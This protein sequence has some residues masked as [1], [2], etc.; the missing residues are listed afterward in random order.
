MSWKG[1][2]YRSRKTRSGKRMDVIRNWKIYTQ[3]LEIHNLKVENAEELLGIEDLGLERE[4][5]V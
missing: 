2:N 1:C 3:E 4:F 5:D